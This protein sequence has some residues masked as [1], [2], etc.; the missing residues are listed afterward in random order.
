MPTAYLV[1]V[2]GCDTQKERAG[3]DSFAL[4]LYHVQT[5][6]LEVP[7]STYK[8]LKVPRRDRVVF[9]SLVPHKFQYQ[10]ENHQAANHGIS[11]VTGSAVIG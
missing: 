8:N 1:S 6:Y 11:L 7:Q 9:F 3:I 5:Q 2:Q 4:R 10:K